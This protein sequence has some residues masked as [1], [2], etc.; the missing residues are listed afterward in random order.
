MKVMTID[1]P[2]NWLIYLLIYLPNYNQQETAKQRTAQYTN[3]HYLVIVVDDI[4]LLTFNPEEN[5][6]KKN[7]STE[8]LKLVSF[9]L[10]IYI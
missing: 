7:I 1:E 9:W 10:T 6:N 4:F 8:T 3:F 5:V 2:T